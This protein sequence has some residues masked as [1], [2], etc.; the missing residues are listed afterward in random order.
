MED[1]PDIPA[2]EPPEISNA[3]AEAFD[4]MGD[5]I[6]VQCAAA[7][8]VSVEAVVLL[9]ESVGIDEQARALFGE[10]LAHLSPNA[11]RGEVLLGFVLGLLAAQAERD[12]E[13]R[14]SCG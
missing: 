1:A 12:K 9:Q 13:R 14:L 8:P 4:R 11:R 6:A 10:R 2:V 3:L 5:F 7:Q